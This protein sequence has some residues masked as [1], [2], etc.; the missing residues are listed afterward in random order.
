LKTLKRVVEIA[1]CKKPFD[2]FMERAMD[3]V[4][5]GKAE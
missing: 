3:E 4:S 5:K 2:P 1:G